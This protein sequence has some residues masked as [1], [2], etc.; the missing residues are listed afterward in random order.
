MAFAAGNFCLV[1][2]NRANRP[3]LLHI[4]RKL[5]KIF[6]K[7]NLKIK[8]MVLHLHLQKL[9]LNMKIYFILKWRFSDKAKN[10][11]FWISHLI[12]TFNKY[13]IYSV[14]SNQVWYFFSNFVA[15]SEYIN[16]WLVEYKIESRVISENIHNS[17]FISFQFNLITF[18]GTLY[19]VYECKH[20]WTMWV[21]LESSKA[22]IA[23][24]LQLIA[25]HI[26]RGQ[27][28]NYKT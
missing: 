2:T 1:T 15:F 13:K 4:V 21:E 9:K 28:S 5:L 25:V 10:I 8:I 24:L 16:F 7:S 12:L 27:I 11:F 23:L 18:H 6:K 3:A 22:V 14:M 20:F 17:M 19:S 26:A